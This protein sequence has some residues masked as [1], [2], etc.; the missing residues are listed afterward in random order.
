MTALS[1]R[2][3][4][5]LAL[6]VVGLLGIGVGVVA[7]LLIKSPQQRAAD[8]AGPKPTT[9]TVA[10]RR[11]VLTD[12]VVM[13]GT[14]QAQ[15]TVDLT[16]SADSAESAIVTGVRVS[17]G[18]SVK[19]AQVLI[20]VAGR[21]VF[22]L[23]GAQPMYRDLRPGMSGTD[24]AQLQAALSGLGIDP[25]ETDGYYGAS[26]KTAVTALYDR[27][28]FQ[29]LPASSSDADDL[30]SAD[31]AVKAAQ[32]A[33]DTAQRDRD[34]AQAAPDSPDKANAVADAEQ[35]VDYAQSDLSDAATA[36]D[37]VIARTGPMVPFGELV[38]LP[39]LPAYVEAMTAEMGKPVSAPALTLSSGKLV[40][41]ATVSNAQRALLK[42]GQSATM[43]AEVD[44]SKAAGKISAVKAA[45][46]AGGGPGPNSGT[47]GDASGSTSQAVFVP[48]AALPA[49][50]AGQNVRVT[51]VA[52]SSGTPVLVVPISAITQG[53][54]AKAFVRVRRSDGKV[55]EV[56]VQIG[57]AAAGFVA[58]TGDV[59]E[60][61]QV[62]VSARS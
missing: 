48:N 8:A 21:P 40:V 34:R 46:G 50:L 7:T 29:P 35:A 42:P 15:Q 1:R 19:A 44:G 53:A 38:F 24:V 26:T 41:E 61:E 55:D 16:P 23:P 25:G 20:E 51:V 54:D 27:L 3:R 12:T 31:S 45:T 6:L 17:P 33:L 18:A 39:T 60:G 28:G 32:R 14:V 4:A 30:A 56:D 22:A 47:S 10:V 37:K 57:V 5:F 62:V 13:R 49:T 2:R 43:V 11:R 58:I 52:A 9:L 59:R 36:R